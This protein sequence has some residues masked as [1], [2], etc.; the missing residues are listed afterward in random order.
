MHTYLRPIAVAVAVVVSLTGCG[1]DAASPQTTT[2]AAG[3]TPIPTTPLTALANPNPV[4]PPASLEA[5]NPFDPSLAVQTA[6]A[7]QPAVLSQAVTGWNAVLDGAT[8]IASKGST[9]ERRFRLVEAMRWTCFGLRASKDP[10][11]QWKVP[12]IPK[13]DSYPDE[14]AAASDRRMRDA[15]IAVAIDKVC[16]GDRSFVGHATTW[17]VPDL[18]K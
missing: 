15:I 17:A 12:A 16:P 14:S 18:I 6:L 9:T 1:K 5:V 13:P 11:G 7:K 2:T 4:V 8:A 3:S 10:T